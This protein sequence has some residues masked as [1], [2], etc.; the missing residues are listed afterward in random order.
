V[1]IINHTYQ[2][3]FVHVPKNAGTSVARYL[4]ELSSYR[5]LEVGATKLG[6]AIAPH[7]RERFGLTKHSTMAEIRAI[8]GTRVFEQYLTLCVVRD[9]FDRVQ[10]L[11]TFLRA[12]DGWHGRL[13]QAEFVAAF[14]SHT[15][16]NQFVRSHFFMTPGPDRLFRPQAFWITDPQTGNPIVDRILRAETLAA[17]L[18]RVVQEIGADAELDGVRVPRL[19]ATKGDTRTTLDEESRAIIRERYAQDFELLGYGEGRTNG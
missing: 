6:V 3:I 8:V 9:P 18:A 10:S 17:D 1:S 11:F 2:F 13:A 4:S 5:D 16:I 15:D 12:W 14:R 19:N 7:V